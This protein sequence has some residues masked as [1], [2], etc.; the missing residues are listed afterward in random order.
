MR[1]SSES[2][3]RVEFYD[4]D[5]MDV[6]YHANYIKFLEVARCDLL[7]K[8]GYGY[9][10]MRATN[11]LFPVTTLNVK[12]VRSLKFGQTAT[13][14]A[15]LLEWENRLKIKY[16]ILAPDGALVTKAET[17][18]MAVKMPKGETCFVCP[19]ELTD[20]VEAILKANNARADDDGEI[21]L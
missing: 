6:V 18:Q 21:L 4:V 2:K 14:R 13:V 9:N 16:E 5:S 20:K 1:I 10:Q 8:I 15:A 3:V 12:Y 7:D 11:Y 17:T 19:K